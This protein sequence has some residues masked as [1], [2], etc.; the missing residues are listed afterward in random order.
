MTPPGHRLR[1]IAARVCDRTT[2]VTVID[3]AIADLQHEA[4]MAQRSGRRRTRPSL[5]RYAAVWQVV[6]Y[7][8]SRS[9]IRGAMTGFTAE[10][11][12]VRRTLLVR[13]TDHALTHAA[14]A[15]AELLRRSAASRGA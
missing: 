7:G 13:M 1:R 8:I 4:E 14:Q 6:G 10:R 2:M 5:G 15:F 3:P 12:L 9:L 11:A